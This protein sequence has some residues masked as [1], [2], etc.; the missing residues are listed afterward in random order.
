MSIKGEIKKKSHKMFRRILMKRRESDGEYET[1]WQT[2]PSKFIKKYGKVDKGTD[3]VVQNHFAS[4][5]YA[6]EVVNNTGF[7]SDV[8]E[9]KSTFFGKL[10]RVR[11]FIKVEAGYIEDDGT[12]QPTTSSLFVGLLK[13]DMPYTFNNLVKF[14][15][16]HL[17]KI[18]KE[19]PADRIAGLG[20]T[21][22]AKQIITTI[23]DHTQGADVLY[24]QKFITS[25]GWFITSS[26]NTYNMATTSN[27]QGK[28]VWKL[29]TDLAEAENNL[30][31]IDRVGDFKFIE[32]EPAST[33]TYHFSGIGDTDN[34]YGR[35]VFK[36]VSVDSDIRNVYNR[37]RIQ[38]SQ[39]DT[40]TS[41]AIRNESW[42]WGDSS[43]S[44]K[45]GIRTYE[46]VNFFLSSATAST[47]ADTIY[48]EFQDA[49]EV[50]KLQTKF[51]PQLDVLDRVN[52]TYQTAIGQ[53]QS[54]W[55]EAKF[56]EHLW[57][58]R[59]AKNI[60]IDGDFKINRISHNLGNFTSNLT[61][62]EI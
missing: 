22:T 61:L 18:F 38:H 28:S 23:R 27:L 49:K 25:G 34:T 56:D 29:M 35:N 62:R 44:M 1:N 11:T 37:V 10:S 2:I 54:L 5:G 20:V 39:D 24:F 4:S 33:S 47:V 9:D 16:D 42:A 60:N 14:K 36:N 19:F 41:F 3:T 58:G 51:V 6:F 45:Y 43:S 57:G 40:T 7:F 15:A 53:G 13:E 55:G 52:A 26:A 50:V 8:S 30:V 46:Y 21:L 17:D 31:Y 59:T 48:T 12:E 32:K